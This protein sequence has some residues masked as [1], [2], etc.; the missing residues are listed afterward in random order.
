MVKRAILYLH[1]LAAVG[2]KIAR[3][4]LMDIASADNDD[5]HVIMVRNFASLEQAIKKAAYMKVGKWYILP[6]NF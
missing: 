1:L 5:D 4:E 2:E 3:R 6:N